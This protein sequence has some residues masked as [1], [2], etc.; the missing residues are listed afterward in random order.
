MP[1]NVYRKKMQHISTLPKVS[2][3]NAGS[4]TEEAITFRD[5][6]VNTEQNRS[7]ILLTS[8][9]ISPTRSVD[10]HTKRTGV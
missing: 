4:L 2:L 6:I 1:N 3:D 9:T 7:E 8:V 10:L 5:G